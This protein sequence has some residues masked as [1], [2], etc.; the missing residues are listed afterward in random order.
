M[1]K[2]QPPVSLALE[3]AKDHMR[4]RYSVTVKNATEL[5]GVVATFAAVLARS[6]QQIRRWLT[7]R[8]GLSADARMKSWWL[9]RD[10]LRLT[11]L[12]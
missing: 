7:L 11:Y 6:N 4:A 1:D 9:K 12:L 8:D 3:L 5:D 10:I 2:E